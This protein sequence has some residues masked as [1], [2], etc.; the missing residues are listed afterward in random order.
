MDTLKIDDIHK[1][2]LLGLKEICRCNR[3]IFSAFNYLQH[4]ELKILM[5]NQ[6]NQNNIIKIPEYIVKNTKFIRKYK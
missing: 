1:F 5:K 4:D 3:D 2:N 6:I